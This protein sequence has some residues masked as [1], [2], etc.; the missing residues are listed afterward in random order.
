MGCWSLELQ[1]AIESKAS[2]MQNRELTVDS[3]L[4]DLTG[5]CGLYVES[6]R[7]PLSLSSAEGSQHLAA[8][9]HAVVSCKLDDLEVHSA[10]VHATLCVEN[11]A[12]ERVE[13]Q[14]RDNW[15]SGQLGRPLFVVCSIAA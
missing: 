6:S 9:A 5:K 8:G 3:S 15:C 11:D 13:W 7:K 2:C 10:T 1:R 14:Q 12:S 4:I